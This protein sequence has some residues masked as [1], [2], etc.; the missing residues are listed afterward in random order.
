[1]KKV[2]EICLETANSLL[3]EYPDLFRKRV[4]S[5]FDHNGNEI[6]IHSF[7][8]LYCNESDFSENYEIKKEIRGLTFVEYPDGE[9]KRFLSLHK[10]FNFPIYDTDIISKYKEV[11]I[12]STSIKLDGSLIIPFNIY[13]KILFKTKMGHNNEVVD[14]LYAV[15]NNV[16]LKQLENFVKELYNSF[17]YKYQPLF[18][19]ISPENKVVVNYEES[20]LKLIQIR[21]NNNGDYLTKENE[22]YPK[23]KKILDKYNI[24][25]NVENNDVYIQ[26]LNDLLFNMNNLYKD[27]FEGFVVR[28]NDDSFYKFKT[29]WYIKHHKIKSKFDNPSS[30]KD[31]VLKL[32]IL[33]EDDDFISSLD[34]KLESERIMYDNIMYLKGHFMKTKLKIISDT[35]D[36]INEFYDN[37]EQGLNIVKEFSLFLKRKY[38]DCLFGFRINVFKEMLNKPELITNKYELSYFVTYYFNEYLE[39]KV[40]LSKKF[41]TDKVIKLFDIK[42]KGVKF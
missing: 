5:L 42:L 24:I 39:S 13:N 40:K 16:R 19:F 27:N 41:K 8:Y 1:M 38:D 2:S 25:F 6:K 9:V 15:I 36:I 37:E 26:T 3:K 10:F 32:I 4:D 20:D 7:G 33:K 12:K 14:K 18:E 29:D 30:F 35:I 22:D 17:H 23:I 28:F 34:L 11:G 31:S 21:D